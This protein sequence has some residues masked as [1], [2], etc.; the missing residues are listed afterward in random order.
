MDIRWRQVARIRYLIQLSQ[1]Y[2][3]AYPATVLGV[4]GVGFSIFWTILALTG[5]I[6]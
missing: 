5:M 2:L 1:L 4:T 6:E 3:F